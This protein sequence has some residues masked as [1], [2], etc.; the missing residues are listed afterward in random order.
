M[1]D[2]NVKVGDREDARMVGKF[3]LGVQSNAGG[4]LVQFYQE[5]RFRIANMWFI[6][7]KR[8]LYTWT[9]ANGQHRNQVDFT[10]CHQR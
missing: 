4:R 2:F 6:Q 3:G 8:R 9:S 7:P 1:S 10:L 5:N